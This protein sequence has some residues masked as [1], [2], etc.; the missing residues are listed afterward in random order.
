MESFFHDRRRSPTASSQPLGVPGNAVRT[1]SPFPTV[2]GIPR[3]CDT[4]RNGSAGTS[5]N[6]V[7]VD[8][9]GWETTVALR[10]TVQ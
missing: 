9:W 4:S 7:R 8:V 5:G 6:G 2:P 3:S 10:D 1:S